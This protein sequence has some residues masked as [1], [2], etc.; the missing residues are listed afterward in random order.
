[1]ADTKVNEEEKKHHVYEMSSIL[2][3]TKAA[4]PIATKPRISIITYK[5]K[6]S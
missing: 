4:T 6:S 5:H 2:V 3:A 1:M